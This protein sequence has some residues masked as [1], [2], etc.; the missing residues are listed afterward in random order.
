M[1]TACAPA[2]QRTCRLQGASKVSSG[3][4]LQALRCTLRAMHWCT[5]VGV[6]RVGRCQSSTALQGRRPSLGPPRPA[7]PYT[8]SLL[9]PGEPAHRP[10]RMPLQGRVHNLQA[11]RASSEPVSLRGTVLRAADLAEDIFVCRIIC[12]PF[13]Q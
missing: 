3:T 9:C 13:H 6:R 4:F 5:L 12:S 10:S 1:R 11:A 8:R 2:T 7:S